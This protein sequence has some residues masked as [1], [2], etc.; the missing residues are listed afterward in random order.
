MRI[1]CL[2]NLR[3]QKD[4]INLLK[5][6]Q[7]VKSKHP[8]STLHLL[9]MIWEDEYHS[10]VVRFIEDNT[11]EDVFLYGSQPG[12][13]SLLADCNIG[14]LASKSEGLPVALLEYGLVGLPVVCTNVGQSAE[15][16]GNK[17]KIV[18]PKDPESLA[19]AIQYYLENKEE[20]MKDAGA[21]KDY[22]QNNYTFTSVSAQILTIY[23]LV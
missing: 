19:K 9:G 1:V 11:L 15:V 18:P 13:L 4:H 23:G 8:E 3:P 16:V 12:V 6:Y 10:S 14:V 21:F 20:R 5:A 7:Q 2:A 22:V 17:G